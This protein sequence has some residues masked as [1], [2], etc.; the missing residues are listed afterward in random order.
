[1]KWRSLFRRKAEDHPPFSPE[2]IDTYVIRVVHVTQWPQAKRFM[3]S[4]VMEA[5]L[6]S[7]RMKGLYLAK[8]LRFGFDD[9]TPPFF[10]KEATVQETMIT[11]CVSSAPG[12]LERFKRSDPLVMQSVMKPSIKLHIPTYT[13]SEFEP[14]R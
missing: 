3:I 2:S 5:P 13:F 14:P 10:L 7:H 8:R 1:M 4:M 9:R 12:Y 6:Y 11:F